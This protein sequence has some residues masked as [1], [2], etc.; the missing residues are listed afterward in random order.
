M[1][2]TLRTNYLP[3]R[4]GRGSPS[5]ISRSSS[6]PGD[7][8]AAAAAAAVRD[9]RLLPAHG[10]F[11][12]ARRQGRARRHPLVRPPG[13]FPHRDPRPDEGADGQER[14]HR[15]DRL[16][17]RLR[18]EEP[19][20][21]RRARRSR[22]RASTCY[23]TLMRGMLDITDNL[24]AGRDRA[25]AR[26]GAPRRR[27][28]LPR[29]RRRQRHGHVL[30]H[31]QRRLRR[32]RFLA[33]RRLRLA[34]A[35]PATTTRPWASPRA[36]AGRRSSATSASSATD[37]Q[38]TN[39]TCVGVGD[40]SGDVFGNA[41]LLLA[42]HEADRGLQPLAHLRR[43]RSRSGAKLGR[44]AA[45]VRS[46]ALELERLQHSAAL[47]GRRGLRAQRQIDRAVAEMRARVSAS[48]PSA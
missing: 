20:A 46:A 40:M 17:G 13:G 33:R 2:K 6:Q 3:A 14:R 25:A 48:T 38:T 44:A 39:F 12:S 11:P 35:P 41:M 8:P 18:R 31:R 15:A 32:V 19:A 9:L 43:S 28:S 5:P 4:R 1:R 26:R 30:R 29:R 34:A 24:A 47:E 21:R 42:A 37:I 7:R 36:A 27:R 22:P 45:A 16:E 10:G 23:K